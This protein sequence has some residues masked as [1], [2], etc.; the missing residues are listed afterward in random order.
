MNVEQGNGRGPFWKTLSGAKGKADRLN[1]AY[2]A[3]NFFVEEYKL[4][5][6][7]P[8]LAGEVIDTTVF[9]LPLIE[10]GLIKEWCP[11]KL[12]DKVQEDADSVRRI[13]RWL[14]DNSDGGVQFADSNDVIDAIRDLYE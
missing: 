7:E 1:G 10:W 13:S 8:K 6:V 2:K 14:E 3:D 4:V 11:S 9:T 12:M 5:L